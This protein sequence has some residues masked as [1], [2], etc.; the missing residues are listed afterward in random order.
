MWDTRWQVAAFAIF[1]GA[2][3]VSPSTLPHVN[4]YPIAAYPHF[5]A[6]TEAGPTQPPRAQHM[7][8]DVKLTACTSGALLKSGALVP[9][10]WIELHG[11]NAATGRCS[12][13]FWQKLTQEVKKKLH[14]GMRPGTC[15]L[16]LT[17]TL[18][19]TRTLTPTLTLTRCA[20]TLTRHVRPIRRA[21]L[22]PDHGHAIG[23]A[24]PARPART[25]RVRQWHCRAR[26]VPQSQGLVV[27]WE[28]CEEAPRL[29]LRL[30][31]QPLNSRA[32]A[33][34][35]PAHAPRPCAITRLPLAQ[36]LRHPA[37]RH[38]ASNIRNI[39]CSL[40]HR[41]ESQSDSD[42][43][44]CHCLSVCSF[45]PSRGYVVNTPCSAHSCNS[46]QEPSFSNRA[47]RTWF[48]ARWHADALSASK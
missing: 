16:T 10:R 27:V 3:Q 4:Q 33:T 20:L 38:P 29:G 2:C 46:Q 40:N 41:P 19:L 18:T 7:V 24:A 45:T 1:W 35:S 47:A 26:K 28:D 6:N 30:V 32:Q 8:T 15:A 37:R 48:P 36:P 23:S 25:A 9:R 44:L 39:I 13:A 21:K 22:C 34:E 43:G 5:C 17:L 14:V 11:G 12:A 42:L 31:A